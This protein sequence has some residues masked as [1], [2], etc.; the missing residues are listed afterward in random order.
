MLSAA[1]ASLT[2]A[3]PVFAN[4]DLVHLGSTSD[5]KEVFLDTKEIKG[6]RFSIV[7]PYGSGMMKAQYKASCAEKRLFHRK[8]ETF[9]SSGVKVD[10]IRGKEV[11]YNPNSIAGRGMKIV[12]KKIGA[13]GW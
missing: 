12:C 8:A 10:S 1:I 2:A 4:N 5:G 13:K 3:Q 11:R 6:T 7:T 9:A